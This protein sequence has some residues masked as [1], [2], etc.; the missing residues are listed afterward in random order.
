[1]FVNYIFFNKSIG[2]VFS[3]LYTDDTWFNSVPLNIFNLCAQ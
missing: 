1:M 3:L 2:A